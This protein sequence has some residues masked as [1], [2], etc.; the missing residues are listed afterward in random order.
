MLTLVCPEVPAVGWG[1]TQA[2]PT[3]RGGICGCLVGLFMVS[4]VE[5]VN[6]NMMLVVAMVVPVA[7]IGALELP[8]LSVAIF[9]AKHSLADLVWA[10]PEI[11]G[12]LVSNLDSN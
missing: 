12:Q 8:R 2:D 1:H 5:P 7:V 6:L 10:L 9:D 4:Q 11:A 3:R